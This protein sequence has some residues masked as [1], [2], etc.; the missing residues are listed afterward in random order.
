MDSLFKTVP[1]IPKIPLYFFRIAN[2]QY[3]RMTINPLIVKQEIIIFVHIYIFSA[4][5]YPPFLNAMLSK[6]KYS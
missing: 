6:M 1:W 4:E 3:Y 2:L 5:A